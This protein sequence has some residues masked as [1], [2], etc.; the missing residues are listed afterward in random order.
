MLRPMTFSLALLLTLNCI[1]HV[2]ALSFRVPD[3]VSDKI[4]NELK[5]PG[6]SKNDDNSTTTVAP[7]EQSQSTTTTTTTTT[8]K[9][10]SSKIGDIG[11]SV[12]NATI[13]NVL[14][15]PE[16]IPSPEDIFQSAKNLFAGYPFD[17]VA[18]AINTFC[19][20]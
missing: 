12:I 11:S 1:Y 19:E 10:I 3:F 14:K 17:I 20:Y 2:N 4:P 9:P 15:I 6:I 18:R 7:V 16:V 5:I 13:G 8:E